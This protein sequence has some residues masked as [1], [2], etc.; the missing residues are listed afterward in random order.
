MPIHIR[1]TAGGNTPGPSPLSPVA[2]PLWAGGRL[3]LTHLWP[4]ADPSAARAA[5]QRAYPA[6]VRVATPGMIIDLG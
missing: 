3:V 2:V 4:G 5:A 1:T 6:D